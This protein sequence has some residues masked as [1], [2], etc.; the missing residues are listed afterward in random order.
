M[1]WTRRAAFT[2]SILIIGLTTPSAAEEIS[3]QPSWFTTGPSMS[4]P[5]DPEEVEAAIKQL[6][7]PINQEQVNQIFLDLVRLEDF[8]ERDRLQKML[9][10]RMQELMKFP[11]PPPDQS[12]P[13]A[14]A[15]ADDPSHD[16]LLVRIETLHLGPDATADDL[17]ARDQLVSKIAGIHDPI[18]REEL[19]ARLEEREREA[20]EMIERP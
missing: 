9:D 10:G 8:S 11:P 14:V 1:V 18:M 3:R 2:F 15:V 5:V 16:E 6:S 19:L 17:R 12:F 20:E 7:Q 4:T 13:K